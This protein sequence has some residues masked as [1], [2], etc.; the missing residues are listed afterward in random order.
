MWPANCH[1]SI[2]RLN[3]FGDEAEEH[4]PLPAAQYV[5][6]PDTHSGEEVSLLRVTPREE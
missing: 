6:H 1:P 2:P 5:V 4:Q 3:A